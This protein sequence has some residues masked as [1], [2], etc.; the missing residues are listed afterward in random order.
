MFQK[1]EPFQKETR[2]PT[3]NFSGDILVLGGV[4]DFL[5]HRFKFGDGSPT[6]PV[7]RTPHLFGEQASR[8]GPSV[9]LR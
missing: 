5:N 9:G 7:R 6:S 4:G 2:L 8:P 1:K 3:S